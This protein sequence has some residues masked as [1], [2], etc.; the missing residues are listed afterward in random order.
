M[1]HYHYFQ[2]LFLL[3]LSCSLFAAEDIALP[4]IP[5]ARTSQE[6]FDF[7]KELREKAEEWKDTEAKKKVAHIQY[8][9][10]DRILALKV[11]D[12]NAINRAL[13]IRWEALDNLAGL[14]ENV[15]AETAELVKKTEEWLKNLAAPPG[16]PPRI[17]RQLVNFAKNLLFSQ[18]LKYGI[19][20]PLEEYCRFEE[21][22][23]NSIG[24]DPRNVTTLATV[25]EEYARSRNDPSIAVGFY[26]KFAKLYKERG[27]YLA[28]EFEKSAIRENLPGKEIVIRGKKLDGND[29]DIQSLRGKVVLIDF[30]ATWCGPCIKEFPNMREQLAKY[31]PRGFVIVGI[32]EDEDV[33]KLADDMEKEKIPWFTLSEKLTKESGEETNAARYGIRPIPR[34]I[35][36]DRE[37]KVITTQIHGEQLNRQL[38]KL[39]Q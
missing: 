9:I 6:Y 7:F 10:T 31:G 1:I 39:F 29:F 19:D 26:T 15:L 14:D 24:F 13:L 2:T 21:E 20:I 23:A 22:V 16:A 17:E 27:H 5:N 38:E 33:K 11:R 18:R 34:M 36:V 8:E 32:S 3:T 12:E 30:W 37:G 35:L 4:A 28:D 25:A